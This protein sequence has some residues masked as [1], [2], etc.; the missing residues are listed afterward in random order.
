[1]LPTPARLP[2][3]SP[4]LLPRL[5]TLLRFLLRPIPLALRLISVVVSPIPLVANLVPFMASPSNRVRPT[6]RPTSGIPASS[7]GQP[8]ADAPHPCPHSTPPR[9]PSYPRTRVSTSTPAPAIRGQEVTPP[10][11]TRHSAVFSRNPVFPPAPNPAKKHPAAT[12][13]FFRKNSY[14]AR[15]PQFSPLQPPHPS[16]NSRRPSLP[17]SASWLP[18][19]LGEGWGEG[20]PVETPTA[21]RLRRSKRRQSSRSSPP[22]RPS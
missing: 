15:D 6:Q 9:H 16:A 5:I 21:P 17:E 19:P 7:Q 2:P 3:R 13:E 18:R 1:M 12:E 22:P 11:P 4:L 20:L 8:F 14:C 10:R